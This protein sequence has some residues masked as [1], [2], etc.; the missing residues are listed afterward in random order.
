MLY[1]SLYLDCYP[2]IYLYL[3]TMST[4][5]FLFIYLFAGLIAALALPVKAQITPDDTLS[6]ESSTVTSGVVD[7]ETVDLIEG[8][9]TRGGNLFHSFS[10]F[11]VDAGERVYFDS[12]A[13]IESILGRVTGNSLSSINGLLGTTGDS[14]AALILMNPNGIVFG[15]NAAL[16][17]QGAFTATTATGIQLGEDGLFSAVD[18]A[19]DQLLSVDPSA[20]FFNGLASASSGI[21]VESAQNFQVAE[22]STL[23]LVGEDVTISRSGIVAPDS[24]I[25][26]V[27]VGDAATAAIDE[28]GKI[29]LGEGANRGS[30][31]VENES[32]INVISSRGGSVTLV[33]NDVQVLSGSQ[34]FARVEPRLQPP[35]LTAVDETANFVEIDATVTVRLSGAGTFLES[36]VLQ[37]ANS[38]LEG[39]L[40]SADSIEVSDGARVHSVTQGGS[41]AS[42]GSLSL[43]ADTNILID[44]A[45][46]Y[47]EVVSE[48]VVQGGSILLS[49][50]NVNI[51]GESTVLTFSIGNGSGGDISLSG[52]R[53]AITGSSDIATVNFG[54]GDAGDLSLEASGDIIVSGGRIGSN[55]IQ[56]SG[57]SGNILLTAGSLSLL[58]S[59]VATSASD[60]GNSGNILVSVDGFVKLENIPSSGLESEISTASSNGEQKGG[61]IE[62]AA[63][64]LVV[65]E[66]SQVASSTDG[67]SEAGNI[68]LNISEKVFVN[69]G[70]VISSSERDS[71]GDGGNIEIVT[72]NIEIVR[73]GFVTASTFGDGN[74]GDVSAQVSE[75]VRLEGSRLIDT[76]FFGIISPPSSLSSLVGLGSQ[77][78]GGN[79]EIETTNLETLDGALITASTGGNGNAGSVSVNARE[80]VF[81]EGLAGTT[82]GGIASTVGSLGSGNGGSIELVAADLEIRN[83]AGISTSTVGDGNAGDIFI[84]VPGTIRIDGSSPGGLTSARSILG[85]GNIDDAIDNINRLA[86]EGR[87]E[88]SQFG[89]SSAINSSVN[90]T[91]LLEEVSPND[92][93]GGRIEISTGSLEVSNG[94]TIDA[95]ALRDSAGSIDLDVAGQILIDDGAIATLSLSGSGGQIAVEADSILLRSGDF[96]AVK[97]FG[98]GFA[99]DVTI[100]ADYIIALEDSDILTFSLQ[101]RG[102]AIDL[103]QTTLFSQDLNF[104]SEDP[105]TVIG[106]LLLNENGRVDINAQGGLSA[107]QILVNDASFLD[108]DLIELPDA[109][110]DTEGLISSA[111]IARDR[112]DTGTLVLQNSDRPSQSPTDTLSTAYSTGTV[113]PVPSTETTAIQEPQAIY[114]L[115]NGRS[116]ISHRC[117]HKQ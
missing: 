56:G 36:S 89:T 72:K 70:N 101:G 97:S 61:N 103:S 42:A 51:S 6:V 47:T 79:I 96:R 94:G 53:I 59:T 9:A 23:S 69:G 52:D 28:N 11:N 107:G 3:C 65:E 99:G 54:A 7:G 81:V 105:N 117:K 25:S 2:F 41:S 111:C 92:I 75:T 17:T 32:F 15:E 31:L 4:L 90:V 112:D 93:S 39:V 55:A 12:P 68:L 46:L 74:A 58:G 91:S 67:S 66:D 85:N 10:D 88:P 50:K 87:V 16:D 114:Q 30:I 5:R 64:N 33:A 38:S 27:A 40:I 71:I 63:A 18:P 80:T 102:G 106:F 100:A 84:N 49:G 77:G 29:A 95:S 13:S 26:V 113:Q 37:G 19:S 76:I 115:A 35:D 108:N 104:A 62:I 20:L 8:G 116:I 45:E 44:N 60:T 34:I 1:Q 21:Q 78:D 43:N 82:P 22:G 48:D 24:Q 57:Q 98:E 83:G 73:G 86:S 14:D 110:V 109:L